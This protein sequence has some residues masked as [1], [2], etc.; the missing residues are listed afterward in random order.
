V[1]TNIGLSEIGFF[2]VGNISR[3]ATNT[4]DCLLFAYRQFSLRMCKIFKKPSNISTFCFCKREA[5]HVIVDIQPR[6]WT[7]KSSSSK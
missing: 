2:S 5:I 3:V 1:E 7:A 6:L 4:L